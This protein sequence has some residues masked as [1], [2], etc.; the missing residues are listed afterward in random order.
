MTT[1]K[2]EFENFGHILDHNHGVIWDNLIVQLQYYDSDL[3]LSLFDYG[4]QKKGEVGWRVS[5]SEN[6]TII[7]NQ[8]RFQQHERQVPDLVAS[9]GVLLY[10]LYP[11]APAYFSIV[12]LLIYP[13]LIFPNMLIQLNHRPLL[14][15]N[16]N[17][18]FNEKKKNSTIFFRL[19]G[20]TWSFK[21][22]EFIKHLLKLCKVLYVKLII[23]E[24]YILNYPTN[25]R[26]LTKNFGYSN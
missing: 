23:S 25:Y 19:I 4:L 5:I 8:K 18:D 3:W 2:I 10:I 11:D 21:R 7:Q 12:P 13:S 1:R 22:H 14:F 16:T 17:F 15:L 26:F 6:S 24:M 20:S 9:D